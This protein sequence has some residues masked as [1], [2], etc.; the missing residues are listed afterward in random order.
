MSEMSFAQM[1]MIACFINGM[2]MVVVMSVI[3]AMNMQLSFLRAQQRQRE[4]QAPQ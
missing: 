2:D 3:Q 1:T 4:Q